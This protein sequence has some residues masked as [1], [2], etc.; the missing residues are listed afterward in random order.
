MPAHSPATL[1]RSASVRTIRCG[2]G[3]KLTPA[4]TPS[5]CEGPRTIGQRSARSFTMPQQREPIVS[6]FQRIKAPFTESGEDEIAAATPEPRPVGELLRERREELRLDID[7]VGEVLRI[8]PAFL[9]ALEQSRP[10]DLPGPTYVIGFVRAYAQHHRLDHNWVLDRYKAESAGVRARPDLTLPVPLGERSLPGG[11]V[12]LVAL[13]LAICGYGTWYYLST[14]ERAR[15]ERVAAVPPTLQIPPPEQAGA[16]LNANAV[17]P[18]PGV[19]PAAAAKAS[20]NSPAT[21]PGNP[22]SPMAT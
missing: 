16:G 3:S 5:R 4:T 9:A 7:G 20:V 18:A 10:Q 15:P 11:P 12:L 8:K 19:D 6:I 17:A 2:A 21:L 22:S 1:T 13:I 14:G